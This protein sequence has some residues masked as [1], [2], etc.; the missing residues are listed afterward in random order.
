MARCREAWPGTMR[1]DLIRMARSLTARARHERKP[2]CISRTEPPRT[3]KKHT[4]ESHLDSSSAAY[5]DP[6]S[7]LSGVTNHGSLHASQQALLPEGCW[8][9]CRLGGTGRLHIESEA[10][11]SSYLVGD[12]VDSCRRRVLVRG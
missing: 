4:L 10:D 9:R 11:G 7:S 2:L 12:F 8:R 5:A 3:R 6:S 1:P